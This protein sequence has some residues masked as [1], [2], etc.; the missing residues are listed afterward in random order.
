MN[1]HTNNEK[2]L[3]SD[4]ASGIFAQIKRS[5]PTQILEGFVYFYRIYQIFDTS[6]DIYLALTMMLEGGPDWQRQSGLAPPLHIWAQVPSQL[7]QQPRDGGGMFLLLTE[8]FFYSTN[9]R[10]RYKE[11]ACY[12]CK[13]TRHQAQ[14]SLWPGPPSPH[15][16]C[17]LLQRTAGWGRP[18]PRSHQG[19][20]KTIFVKVKI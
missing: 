20:K 12:N 1:N 17:R 13:C 3:F 11:E 9:P 8:C 14:W 18:A 16:V 5:G 2:S 10:L 15:W 4:Q 7:P 6:S 19:D